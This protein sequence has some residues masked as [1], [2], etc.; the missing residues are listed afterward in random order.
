MA[1]K[2]KEL[3]AAILQNVIFMPIRQGGDVDY[4]INF[5]GERYNYKFNKEEIELIKKHCGG[6]PFLIRVVA[7]QIASNPQGTKDLENYLARDYEVNSI[8]RRV[9]DL[10]T[11]N[12]KEVMVAI[13]EG[14]APKKTQTLERLMSLGLVERDGGKYKLFGQ[15]LTD[16]IER[17]RD[18]PEEEV[19]S[20]PSDKLYLDEDSAVCFKKQSI[21][22]T[23]SNQEYRVLK[24]LLV[25]VGKLRTREQIG[26]IMWGEESYE[27]FSNWA[28]DQ[29]TSK[30]RRKIS[31]L[32]SSSILT[33]VRGRGYKIEI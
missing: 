23:F 31:D 1:D 18:I 2:Y 19:S 20:V 8:A 4:V 9:Y 11:K 32:G 12:E 26:E 5:F 10:R 16:F 33:T 29:L 30:I 13:V 22:E 15:L 24:Y 28:I 17:E 3:N 21:D 27:K 6:H 7:K 14:V 25:N